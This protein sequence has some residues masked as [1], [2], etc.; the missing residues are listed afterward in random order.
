[1]AL[2]ADH[3][4]HVYDDAREL[5]ASVAA[6]VPDVVVATP[7]NRLRFEAAMR[8]D[9]REPDEVVFVDADELLDS[10][11]V[12]GTPDP[13][14]FEQTVG[15][16]LDRHG[17]RERTVRVYGEMVQLLCERGLHGAALLLEGLWNELA[18]RRRF[19][20]LC[21]YQREAADPALAEI[22][23]LHTHVHVA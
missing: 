2:A 4:V 10:F 22:C 14:R 17:A 9:G 5:A 1:M 8:A 16:L 6:H 13:R 20:L 7:E 15:A 21:G 12:D 18:R 19:S 3:T 23:A 11:L